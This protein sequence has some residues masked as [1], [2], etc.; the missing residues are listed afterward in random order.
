M[1]VGD[2]ITDVPPFT[3]LREAGGVTLSFNGNR[4]AL[5][6]AELAAAAADTAPTRELALAFAAGGRAGVLA[7]V[8]SFPQVSKPLPAWAC[9]AKRAPPLP[10]PR[11]TPARTS[12]ASA[13]PAWAEESRA[14]PQRPFRRRRRRAL[15]DRPALFIFGPAS[16]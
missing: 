12:A 2:S 7:A 11:P 1:Y 16:L 10:T 4:Y 8:R 15:R 9:S 5:A 14:G 3:A 13:S 6:A